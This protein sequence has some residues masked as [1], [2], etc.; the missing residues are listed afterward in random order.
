MK[1]NKFTLKTRSEVEDIVISTLADV[2]IEGVEIQD[3]QPL[4]ESDKQQMFVDIMPDIPDDDGI[5]YLNFY[6]DVDENKEKVLADVRAALAEMQEFLDLGECTITESETEDKDW[7]NNWKQYFKQF[8]VDDILIIPSWEEVK[9]EDRD[10]MIIHIDP[11]TAFGTGMHETTQLCIR[12]LKKYVT[13][14]TELLDVG[15]GSGILSIIALKLGARHAVGTDLDPCAVPAVEENKEVNGIPVEAFDMMIGNIID[16]KEVQDKVGYEKYDIVTANILADVLVPLTPVIVHQMK[17]G[18]VY[19]TSGILDVKEEVVKEAVVAAG[20][21]VVEVTHQGEWVSVTAR[22]PMYIKKSETPEE[23][24][25]RFMY[26]FFVEES[27]IYDG[28]V[29]I[30][31]SDVNHIKNVLRMRPGEKI[32]VSTGGEKEYHC[33]VSDFPEGEVLAAVEEVTAADRELP[34]G[35]VLFQGLPKGDK[36]ELIIQKAVELGATEIV[37]VEMKRCVV[38]LDRKKAEKKAER[39]QTIAL[40]A[41][42]QSKRM[43]IPTVHMPVTFQQALA[44]MAESDVR[45]MPYENAEGMEGTRKILESIEPGESIAILIGPEGG[46]DEAEVE[47]A[48]KAKVEPITLGKRILR[49]E[50]AGMT[51]LSILVYLLEGRERTR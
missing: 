11:G 15:T 39:W 48:M 14:D 34:S 36:M 6:L 41:A 50:T 43:Q 19:I 29:H 45:L 30:T 13:K 18:A 12:Q 21:E 49:T 22:K 42:K 46:I 8:Y 23:K 51:V 3:K 24:E 32:L 9:P 40:G 1:W 25:N 28:T 31:G 27:Q 4:T 5:A 35:I 47:M 33:A 16:D 20:L 38:K 26:R 44:M 7:I 37:P 17:P 10:K 2:G